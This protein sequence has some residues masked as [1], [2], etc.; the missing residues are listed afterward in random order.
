M[1]T[2][3]HR[4]QDLSKLQKIDTLLCLEVVNHEEWHHPFDQVL[5]PTHPKRHPVAVVPANHAATEVRLERVQ[6]LRVPLVLHHGELGQNLNSQRHV[7][8]LTDSDVEA[9][10]TVDET[11][12]PLGFKIHGRSRTSSL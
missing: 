7:L 9:A 11:N 3:L 2:A 12:D 10:F 8:V 4:Q 6:D 1:I 5:E